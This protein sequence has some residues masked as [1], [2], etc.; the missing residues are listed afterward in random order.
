MLRRREPASIV[1]MGRLAP[2]FFIIGID[3]CAC[4]TN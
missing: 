1:C 3:C 2:A 4:S